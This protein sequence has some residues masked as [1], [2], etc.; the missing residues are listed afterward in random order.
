MA[1][2]KATRKTTRAASAR[3]AAAM[4]SGAPRKKSRRK[5]TAKKAARKSARRATRKVA[6]KG[7]KK[8]ARKTA[9]DSFRHRIAR[10]PSGPPALHRLRRGPGGH[11]TAT[12]PRLRGARAPR[13]R[14]RG[15]E[16][17]SLLAVSAL[18]DRSPPPQ[19][20]RSHG[21]ESADA[22]GPA[23]RARDLPRHSARSNAIYE[24]Q[25]G[26][27]A[28]TWPTSVV[29][30]TARCRFTTDASPDGGRPGSLEPHPSVGFCLT[31]G[32]ASHQAYC[33]KTQALLQ[34]TRPSSTKLS[35]G[36]PLCGGFAPHESL[37]F[38]LSAS[39]RLVPRE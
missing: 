37:S 21:D 33:P 23:Q 5:A 12:A 34:S 6:G 25:I 29:A 32:V 7:P 2:K 39:R 16:A 36:Q 38:E 31:T 13:A 4:A 19:A 1:G 27:R 20:A 26:G 10:V 17:G 8:T 24:S 28:E 15:G 18:P 22:R 30:R 9:G 14:E 35:A 3:K 11:V